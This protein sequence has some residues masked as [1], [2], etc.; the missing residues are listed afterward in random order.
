MSAFGLHEIGN[1]LGKVIATCIQMACGDSIKEDI[2]VNR[3]ITTN[4]VPTRIWDFIFSHLHAMVTMP[5]VHIGLTKR[6]PWQMVLV[7]DENTG[8][9]LSL[10]REERYKQLCQ[11][12]PHERRYHYVR[13]LAKELNDGL[14]TNDK[15]LQWDIIDETETELDIVQRIAASM[16]EDLAFPANLIK[17]HALVLFSAREHETQ[18]IRCVMVDGGF[19]IID[20]VSWNKY[21]QVTEG[22]VTDTA[23]D[24]PAP[25]ENPLK[26]LKLTRKALEKKGV[27]LPKH[28]EDNEKKEEK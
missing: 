2:R 24:S 17:H 13:C 5:L 25:H 8:L 21:L 18:S 6:G 10:M 19:D 26:G 12:D 11:D 28:K 15:Q 22:I 14:P 27:K 16:I 3:L 20:E 23:D 7:F 1:S 4:S 9:L